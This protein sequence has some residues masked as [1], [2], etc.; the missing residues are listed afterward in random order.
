[1]YRILST[2]LVTKMKHNFLLMVP[3]E[4][5][6]LI[7]PATPHSLLLWGGFLPM[8]WLNLEEGAGPS[9]SAPFPFWSV[10]PP[11]RA[12]SGQF[13]PQGCPGCP[14]YTP[15]TG[16]WVCLP[17]GT[18]I[19]PAGQHLRLAFISRRADIVIG[20]EQRAFLFGSEF[21]GGRGCY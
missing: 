1:M 13:S 10:L 15:V 12:Q 14:V 6:L 21:K 18:A 8:W 3:R 20:S 7:S 16:W 9:S 5:T 19:G 4:R 2:V 17:Q 11:G